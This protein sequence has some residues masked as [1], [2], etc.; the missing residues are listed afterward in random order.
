MNLISNGVDA[1]RRQ[2]GTMTVRLSSFVLGGHHRKEL[3]RLVTPQYLRGERRYRFLRISVRDE[4]AGMD[5]ATR[6]RIF[7]PF[8]T[9]KPRGEGT[10]M[11]L[12]VVDGIVSSLGGGVSVESDP[13]AGTVFHVVLPLVD[14]PAGLGA[15]AALQTP[16]GRECVLFVDDE[17]AIVRMAE[18]MLTSLGYRP[19]VTNQSV[20]ALRL[21]E[22][23]P[24]RFDLVITDHVMPDLT[25]AEL[26]RK[27]T[28]IRPDVPVLLCTGFRENLSEE[29]VQAAGICEVLMKPVGRADLA[30]AIRRAFESGA[31]RSG[32]ATGE[33]SGFAAA[34]DIAVGSDP[35][36]EPPGF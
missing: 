20:K 30:Q 6:K 5:E 24:Q 25:G 3:P 12:A 21:F 16:L 17:A 29:D 9:T 4:G 36:R 11:G 1:M 7:E 26:A 27:L 10:G 31:R 2:G 28:G 32:S 18:L 19:V 33:V 35:K 13:G 23:N 14:A 34:D 8:F 15:E 22:E